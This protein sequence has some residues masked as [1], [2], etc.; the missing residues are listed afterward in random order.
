M[1]TQDDY[2]KKCIQYLELL[3]TLE[4]LEHNTD[5]SLDF[6]KDIGKSLQQLEREILAQPLR[7][8]ALN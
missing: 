5:L 1:R 2:E 7:K 6:Q 3:H 8:D 4:E